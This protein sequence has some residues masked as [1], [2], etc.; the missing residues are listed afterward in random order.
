MVVAL[1][2]SDAPHAQTPATN[3]RVWTGTWE[4]HDSWEGTNVVG[5]S[6]AEISFVYVE[7]RDEFGLP[8]WDSR[9]LTWSAMWEDHRFDH[10]WVEEYGEADERGIYSNRSRVDIVT[11][12]NGGGTLELGPAIA[13]G[14]DM[15]TAEQKEQLRPSCVTT[16]RQREAGPTPAPTQSKR[17]A[18]PAPSL[19]SEYELTGCAYEKMW[20]MG[21]RGAGSMSVSVSARVTAVMEVDPD[22]TGTYGSFVP[23]PGET[24]TFVASV[25]SGEARFR[26]ELDPQATS[27]FPGYATNANVDDAFLEKHQLDQLPSE[28]ANDDPDVIFHPKHHRAQEWSRRGPLVVETSTPQSAAVVTV[29]ALDYGA[30][31]RLRAFVKS[32]GCGDWQP[33]PVRFG[34]ETRESVSIPLDDNDNLMA[35]A[36]EDYRSLPPS[37]D[38]D[39]DPKGNGTIGDGLTALEEYRGFVTSISPTCE[40]ASDMSYIR[41]NP[42]TKDLFIHSP[43]PILAAEAAQFKD[44]SG[45]DVHLICPIHYVDNQTRVVNFTMQSPTR[46]TF[47]GRPLTQN[48]PQHGLYL[49]D[50]NLGAG[51]EGQSPIGP[52][53]GVD[54]VEVDLTKIKHQSSS[55]RKLTRVVRHELGHAVGIDHHGDGNHVGP[56]VLLNMPSCPPG[57]TPGV[58]IDSQPA[59]LVEAVAV[60]QGQNSGNEECPMKYVQWNWYV[61]PRRTL[62]TAGTVYFTAR[63]DWSRQ[64]PAYQGQILPYQTQLEKIGIGKFDHSNVG[65]GI[66]A[67]RGRLNHAGDSERVCSSQLQVSDAPGSSQPAGP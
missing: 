6:Q 67:L 66:N 48:W 39:A 2:G 26:F 1:T 55:A 9:R 56:I 7:G 54:K 8:R 62:T 15:L 18:L 41:T 47:R 20:L 61:P 42:R 23:V 63:G 16:Y 64:L 32:E 30:V 21:T 50:A 24:L 19:P 58:L 29:T 10:V 12:C 43:D 49:V 34:N 46:A 60:R 36:L 27:H 59:C 44:S 45:L 65:T 5:R 14:E 25:P 4:E 52:P 17:D 3:Q 28:Y 22:L 33:V 57:M 40:S 38:F 31:G 11:V 35:D 53:G 37:A 51:I 13:A